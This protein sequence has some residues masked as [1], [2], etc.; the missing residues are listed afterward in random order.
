MTEKG[1]TAC[2]MCAE[3]ATGARCA[4][5]S[6]DTLAAARK[7]LADHPPLTDG[8]PVTGAY[9]CVVCRCDGRGDGR[10]TPVS[11]RHLLPR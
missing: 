8:G 7:V 6:P 11:P 5:L 4:Y 10:D 9:T 2:P 3:I 1:L